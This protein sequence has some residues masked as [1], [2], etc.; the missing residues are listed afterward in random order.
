MQ[1]KKEFS[2]EEIVVFLW[3]F[4]N[5]YPIKFF[6]TSVH[7]ASHGIAILLTGGEIIKIELNGEAGL[8]TSR[9]GVRLLISPAGY[10]G[11][12]IIGGLLLI[13]SKNLKLSQS[14]IIGLGV[15]VLTL[16]L[17]YIDSY[18]SISF[19]IVTIFCLIL[20][21]LALKTDFDKH[22]ALFLSSFFIMSSV[23]DVKVYLLS[24]IAYKT[25]AGI[26]AR[27]L[28]AEFLTLPIALLFFGLSLFVYYKSVRFVLK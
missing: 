14:M 25:D 9:G 6:I 28:G 8:I 19:I 3:D 2:K 7:E 23:D 18:T 20:I 10:I 5:F 15:F 27:Y 22:I 24:D 13:S 1:I 21:A 26:L 12:A 4:K 16:N 11:T 17:I